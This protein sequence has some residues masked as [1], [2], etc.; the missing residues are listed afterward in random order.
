MVVYLYT[1]FDDIR[2]FSNFIKNY[3]KFKSGQ[4]HKLLVCYKLLNKRKIF[5]CRNKLKK[6]RHIEFID[7]YKKNDF[8]Y[9]SYGRISNLYKNF[10]IFFMNSHSYPIK[11]NWLKILLKHFRNKTLIGTSGSY[12]SHLTSLKIKKIFKI[13]KYIKNYKYLK[14][15]FK[16]FPNP[17]LR[18]AN[19][20]IKSNDF[21]LFNKKKKYNN[22]IDAW[23][24]ESGKN[25][26]TNYF[27][28]LGYNIYVVNSDGKKF[29]E[30]YWHDSQTYCSKNQKKLLISD[31]HTRKYDKLSKFNK[32]KIESKIWN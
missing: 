9:G 4:I 30:N 14:K 18:T 27:K 6:T 21:V 16:P 23:I 28:K 11:N 10:T 12:E 17:H 25:G 8:D 19:F 15:N 5:I 13:I 29:N 1:S 3:K 24:S 26:L 2:S 32:K 22:K 20:L 31:K 7:P